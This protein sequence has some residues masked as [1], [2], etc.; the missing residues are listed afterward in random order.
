M[1]DPL[2]SDD[3]PEGK[4]S[5]RFSAAYLEPGED[6]GHFN[7]MRKLITV[8]NEG[9]QIMRHTSESGIL[10]AIYRRAG[11]GDTVHM[12]TVHPLTA[13]PMDLILVWR[14]GAEA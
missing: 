14:P 12:K 10:L 6:R 11:K 13:E 1:V 3:P 9:G 2:N 4:T 5:I 8:K 7:L